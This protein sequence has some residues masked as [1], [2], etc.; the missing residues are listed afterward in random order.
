MEAGVAPATGVP[1]GAAGEAGGEVVAKGWTGGTDA[2]VGVRPS[3]GEV[4]VGGGGVA[5]IGA[6]GDG[7]T[8]TGDVDI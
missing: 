8:P 4:A 7:E 6:A 1:P 5:V 2:D 3:G